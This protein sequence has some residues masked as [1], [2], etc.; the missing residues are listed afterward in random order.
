[1]TKLKIAE[2][3]TRMD[4]GGSPDIVRLI[5]L[6]LNPDLYDIKF[7]S[8]P[9]LFP[10]EET[11]DFLRRFKDRTIIV[12]Q[13]RRN[14]NLF[15]D[16][17]AFM[18]LYCFFKK[19]KFHIVHTHTAKAGALGRL[20]AYLAGVPVIIHTPHGHNFYGYFNWFFSRLIII[21]EKFCS[22]FTDKIICLTELEKRDFIK[23][24]VADEKKL[25][26]IYQGL[27]LDKYTDIGI[28]KDSI[29]RDFGIGVSEGVVG[30]IGRLEPIKG[31]EYLIEAAEEVLKNKRVKFL[32]VGEGS[33]RKRL[34]QRVKEL[35]REE[36]FIF[37]GW[38]QDIPQL[39]SI[40]DLLVLP[41]L[42]EAVGM[43]LLEAQMMGIPIVA[44]NVGGIPEVVRDGLTAVLVKPQDSRALASAINGLLQ[45]KSR[46]LEMSKKAKN[47]VKDRFAIKDMVNKI[48]DLYQGLVKKKNVK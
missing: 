5:C 6:H 29:R 14:I 2:I 38:R 4:W 17:I 33:L 25:E 27:D 18:Q 35:G 13:L 40:M 3:I 44:T 28:D 7:I 15:R 24:K 37:S 48:S 22:H 19:E 21:I 8:G 11:K 9:T 20:A 16:L 43:V 45:D 46:R 23:F 34:E 10:A 39:L 36:N 47:W 41:S 31:L 12:S 26:V 30:F 1:M 42:N 32:I